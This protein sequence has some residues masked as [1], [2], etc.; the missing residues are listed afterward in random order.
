[1]SFN[2]LQGDQVDV[3]SFVDDAEEQ[4]L[5]AFSMGDVAVAPLMEVDL[6]SVAANVVPPQ[7]DNVPTAAFNSR[8]A[9][10]PPAFQSYVPK[11]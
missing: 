4:A 7:G 6:E 5:L 8:Q 9:Q 2:T 11:M 3:F 10:M 1:M